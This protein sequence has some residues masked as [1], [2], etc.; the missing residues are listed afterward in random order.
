MQHSCSFFY[1]LDTKTG[2]LKRYTPNNRRKKLIVQKGANIMKRV[3]IADDAT[4]MRLMLKQMLNQNGFEVVGEAENGEVAVDKYKECKPDIVTMDITM[5][6]LNG[7]DA[8]KLI[9]DFDSNAKVIMISAMGQEN[10]VRE[11]IVCGAKSF[12]VKPFKEDQVLKVLNQF[13]CD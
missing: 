5:P 6:N 13:A 4:F 3:L 2:K 1:F 9:M 10:M 11:S 7:I 8:L 12:V